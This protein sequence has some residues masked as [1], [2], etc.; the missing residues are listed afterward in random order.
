MYVLPKATL[1]AKSNVH[2]KKGSNNYQ[3]YQTSN[4]RKSHEQDQY[5]Q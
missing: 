4:T 5:D 3:M 1:E 2:L